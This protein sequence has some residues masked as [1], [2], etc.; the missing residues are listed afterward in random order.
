MV[1]LESIDPLKVDFRV[2]EIYLKQVQVGQTLQISLDAL[3]GR[4][5]EGK[6]FA[7]NPLVDAPG[8]A[9]VLR[10][11]VHNPD[12]ALRPG[13]FARVRLITRQEHDA[14]VLPEQAV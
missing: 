6:V 9:I 10:A 3:P 5:Y 2:P 7:I 12:P 8:R 1:N 11:M 13:V 4:T 14:L